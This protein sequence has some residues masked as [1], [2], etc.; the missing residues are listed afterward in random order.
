MRGEL[1][2]S[3]EDE[4]QH[5]ISLDSAELENVRL[6]D[7]DLDGISATKA[8]LHNCSF[9]GAWLNS[10]ALAGA[11]VINC[12][13]D[14]AQLRSV[15]F[16]RAKFTGCDFTL[17]ELSDCALSNST[18]KDCYF[19]RTAFIG[20]FD[21]D[22]AKI[23][24]SCEVNSNLVFDRITIASSFKK[25]PD[26]FLLN[27]GYSQMEIDYLRSLQTT[28][29]VYNSVFISYARSDS[30]FVSKLERHL[31]GRAI[32]V[33]RDKPDMKGGR[34]WKTQ[35]DEAI[36]VQKK[37]LVVCS[38]YSLTRS[39]VIDEIERAVTLERVRKE[40]RLF[41]VMIDD[42]VLS[43]EAMDD[44]RERVRS[45]SWTENWIHY[46]RKFS[47]TDFTSWRKRSG[48]VVAFNG[49]LADLRLVD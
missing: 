40:S 33:W 1:S 44:G 48:F 30:D 39:A 36:L 49:L 45:G 42:Y 4:D 2:I 35:I 26:W 10:C 18:F 6:H 38:Q 46:L 37:T 17:A 28:P 12:R 8:L 43:E 3:A 15:D 25:L 7:A 11:S 32:P 29:L 14:G 13:F 41:P 16:S 47:I 27:G 19:D 23:Q 22:R 5:L 34:H 20:C 24:R 31:R 9:G 21:L